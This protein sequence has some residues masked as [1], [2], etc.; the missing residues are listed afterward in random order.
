MVPVVLLNAEGWGG[1]G[2][3]RQEW[4]GQLF[5]LPAIYGPRHIGTE[6]RRWEYY[7]VVNLHQGE[8]VSG[9]QKTET[10]RDDVVCIEQSQGWPTEFRSI[11]PVIED[12]LRDAHLEDHA[13]SSFEEVLK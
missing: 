4:T 2:V 9:C 3:P 5:Y 8:V 13:P 1:K 11:V 6:P 12:T 7:S 10:T